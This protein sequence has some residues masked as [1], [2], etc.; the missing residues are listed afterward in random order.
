MSKSNKNFR[1]IYLDYASS[2][3]SQSAN[4]GAIHEL[5][6]KEKNKLENA[7]KKVAKILGAQ[8]DEIIFTSGATEANNLAILGII[9]PYLASPYSR[10][11]KEEGGL[12]HIVTTNMDDDSVLEVR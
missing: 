7:R 5:G 4:P 8:S 3:L 9:Y 6:V 1:K 2:A 10:G 11:R 12:P